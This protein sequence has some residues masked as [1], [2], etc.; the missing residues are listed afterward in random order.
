MKSIQSRLLM[1]L[2]LFIIL[3]YFLFVFL[4]YGYTKTSIERNELEN[5]REQLEGTADELE[6]YSEDLVNLPYI[7]YRNPDLFRMFENGFEDSI[8][9]DSMAMEKSIET[10]YLTRNE[11]RQ[12]RFYIEQDQEAFTVYNAMISTRK[13]Q[14]GL[15][16]HG[17]I[18]QLYESSEQYV[19]E[20][21]HEIVNYNQAAILP[22]SDHAM[23]MTFHHKIVDVLS[24]EFLGIMTMDIDLDAY[25]KMMH[26]LSQEEGAS[27]FLIDANDRIMYATDTSLIGGQIP[28]QLKQR[29][30]S[31]HADTEE[32]II[33]SKK[34]TGALDQ[35]TV[36]KIIPSDVLFSDARKTAFINILVGLAVGLLGLIM[37][38]LI[39]YRITR[40]IQLLSR[41]VRS[42]EGGQTDIPF[43]SSRD[44]E[45]GHLESHMQA[46]MNRIHHHIDREYKLE[47]E[48][49]KNEFR[50]L[51][52]QVNPHFLFNALQSIGAV[53]LRANAPAV[54]RL[55]TSLSSMM[56]YS[57]QANQWVTVRQEINYINA[58]LA[59]QMERF[60]HK[61]K[62]TIQMSEPVLDAQ[63][64]SMILQ[65]LVEN[66]FKHTYEEGFYEAQLIIT[67]SIHEERLH[68]SVE[69]DG[70][71]L[72]DAELQTLRN[73]MTDSQSD[74]SSQIGLKNIHDRLALHYGSAAVF[75]VHSKE[76]KGFS[77]TIIIPAAPPFSNDET[78][79]AH[80]EETE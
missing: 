17:P 24:N 61:V 9:F 2:F 44:D 73:H 40:P 42:I 33:L 37:V 53:A 58:Y 48:N 45:I 47:I 14:P 26:G 46:M 12:L 6:Q 74:G 69:N 60:G 59:L 52:S 62:H 29:I 72:G 19:I 78:M 79:L 21:P 32:E 67:G 28:A 5:S 4:I 39:S 75:S 1:L 23:V 76:G 18:K 70:P 35:W 63:I 15:L 80:K 25:A 50:A 41:K 55:L 64:P 68:L 77:V 34:L 13:P 20:P 11:I 71:G 31:L 66:F 16:S 10:F 36:V 22:E 30:T 3:P 49:R 27:A 54:Y 8:Y 56:R 57:M 43:D 7:L 38:T 51:K 65:P